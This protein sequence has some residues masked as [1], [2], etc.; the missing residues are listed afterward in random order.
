MIAAGA[1]VTFGIG[2]SSMIVGAILLG[3]LIYA[4]TR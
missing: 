3:M 2:Y 1:A 4:R